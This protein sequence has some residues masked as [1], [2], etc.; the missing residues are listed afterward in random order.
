MRQDVIEASQ[1]PEGSE[2]YLVRDKF[3]DTGYRILYPMKNKEGKYLW[4]NIFYG[5]IQNLLW[6]LF[7]LALVGVFFWVYHHDT[8]SLQD[9]AENP[10]KYCKI[11]TGN[12]V[13]G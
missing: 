13:V 9:V 3:S 7:V 8:A 1:L 5:G 11:L 12:I 6:I 2:V 10:C 4:K